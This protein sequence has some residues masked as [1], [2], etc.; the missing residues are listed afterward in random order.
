MLYACLAVVA[1]FI[2]FIVTTYF[3]TKKT[4]VFDVKGKSVKLANEGMTCKIYIDG[5]V[6]AGYHMPQFIKGETFKITVNEEDI[7]IKC[8]SNAFGTKLSVKAYIGK[9]EIYNNGVEI[10]E[11]NK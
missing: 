10:K 1:V 8:K 11:K 3:V 7:E 9:E 6:V 4:Y 2:I 5:I